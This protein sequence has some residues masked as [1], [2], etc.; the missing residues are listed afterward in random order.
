MLL[1]ISVRVSSFTKL[2]VPVNI[3]P[4]LDGMRGCGKE[5]VLSAQLG[6]LKD[7]LAVYYV[8]TYACGHNRE[9]CC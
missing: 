5:L 9:I 8:M 6:L 4:T 3:Y 1:R 7:V 2:V